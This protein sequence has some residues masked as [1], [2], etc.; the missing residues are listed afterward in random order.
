ML[1]LNDM[2][3][4]IAMRTSRAVYPRL[5]NRDLSLISAP[6]LLYAGD[7][8]AM[9]YAGCKESAGLLPRTTFFS[10]AGFDHAAAYKQSDLVLPHIKKFL[11]EVKS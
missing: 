1:L 3:A 8:D 11:A 5:T 10:L 9:F 6:C 2:K 4:L 7:L